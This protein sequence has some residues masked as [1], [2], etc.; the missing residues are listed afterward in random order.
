MDSVIVDPQFYG[1]PGI[2]HGG[3]VAGLL[4]SSRLYSP[5]QIP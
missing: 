4:A 3:Y 2:G 1:Y 5:N